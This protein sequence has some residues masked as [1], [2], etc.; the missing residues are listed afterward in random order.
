MLREYPHGYC[1][2]QGNL[3]TYLEKRVLTL[4]LWL[5]QNFEHSKTMPQDNAAIDA[6]GM[7]IPIRAHFKLSLGM[8]LGY[9]TYAAWSQLLVFGIDWQFEGLERAG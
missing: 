8:G 3:L 6:T 7:Y 2:A 4:C 5:F 1:R 9:R